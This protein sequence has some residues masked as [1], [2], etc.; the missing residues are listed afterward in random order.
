MRVSKVILGVDPGLSYTGYAIIVRHEKGSAVVDYGY[1]QL[2]KEKDLPKRVALFHEFF[3][4]KI[5]KHGA[6]HLSL[7][8]PF[9][10]KNAQTFLKLGYLRGILYLLASK[11]NLQIQSI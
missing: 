9:L 1:L 8:T 3:V 2:N 4:E 6:T 5:T 10:G 11:H 7:E